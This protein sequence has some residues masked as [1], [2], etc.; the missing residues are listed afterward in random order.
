ME[1][2]LHPIKKAKKRADSEE[3][4]SWDKKRGLLLIRPSTKSKDRSASKNGL[5]ASAGLKPAPC[6]FEMIMESLPAI[7]HGSINYSAGALLSGRLQLKVEDPSGEVRLTK[8]DMVLRVDTTTRKPVQKNC[9]GCTTKHDIIREE[10]F[11]SQPKSFYKMGDNQFPWSLLL[12]G[13]LPGITY[14]QLGSISYSFVVNATTSSDENITF[15]HPLLIQRAVPP[16]PD[17]ASTR[18]FPPTHLTG[19]VTMPPVVH[20]VGQLPVT[21]TVSGV[22]EKKE[23]NQT[24]WRLKKMMWR[25]EEH[26]KVK[27]TR[28]DKHKRKV[29]DDEAVQHVDSKQLGNGELKSGWKTDFDTSGGEIMLDFQAQLSTKPSHKPSCDVDSLSGLEVKH[30][31]VVE[32]IVAQEFVPNKNTNL[33]TPTGAAR[34]LR[35]QFALVVSDQGGIGLSWE[36]EMP[37]MYEDVPGSP[38]CYSNAD[39]NDGALGGDLMEDCHGPDLEHTDLER[40]PTSNPCE[41]PVYRQRRRIDMGVALPIEYRRGPDDA[42]GAGPSQPRQQHRVFW[43]DELDEEPQHIPRR[44]VADED[45]EAAVDYGEQ[46]ASAALAE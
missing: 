1:S 38:P 33:V 23:Q 43:L 14:C 34:V 19:R 7:L 11:L 46:S 36:E 5:V 45:C 37:P 22:V 25:I 40:V 44:R 24:R 8:L 3:R 21:L 16:G 28:C 15:T 2:I 6:R 42:D 31:L 26:S 12:D 35:M 30:S 39:Q 4:G 29:S 32:L 17:H 10:K 18:I 9:E 13:R 20:P 27:S 41:P